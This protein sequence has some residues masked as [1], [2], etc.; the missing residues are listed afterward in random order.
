MTVKLRLSVVAV[1]PTWNHTAIDKPPRARLLRLG[2]TTLGPPMSR[3]AALDTHLKRSED[4]V[5]LADTF[6]E[7]IPSEMAGIARVAWTEAEPVS[8]NY[9]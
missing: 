6:G 4:D 2:P 1:S 5:A 8:H 9:P 3:S 7:I